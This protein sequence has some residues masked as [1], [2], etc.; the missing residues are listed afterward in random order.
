[1]WESDKKARRGGAL[2]GKGV[3]SAPTGWGKI[4]KKGKPGA[5]KNH[6]REKLREKKAGKNASKSKDEREPKTVKREI[7]EGKNRKDIQIH[8]KTRF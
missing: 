5:G 1:V 2:G 4:T 6:N 7:G 8:G 3:G